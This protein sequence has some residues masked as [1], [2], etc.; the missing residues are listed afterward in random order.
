MK[1]YS[2]EEPTPRERQL[3]ERCRHYEEQLQ[4]QANQLAEFKAVIEAQREEIEH[5]GDF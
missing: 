5:L 2:E 4:V 3:L 1:G